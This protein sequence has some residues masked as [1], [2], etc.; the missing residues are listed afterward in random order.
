MPRKVKLE[1]IEEGQILAE[2]LS[3]KYDQIL[4][5]KGTSLNLD[6]HIR[7]LKMWGIN[8]ILIF[9][10]LV[11]ASSGSVNSEE[12][13]NIETILLDEI[14]WIIKNENDKLLFDVAVLSRIGTFNNE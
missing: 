3:N 8:E 4:I 9:D 11:D 1:D 5:K 2:T 10:D 6:S 7:V 13:A 14:G 12:I